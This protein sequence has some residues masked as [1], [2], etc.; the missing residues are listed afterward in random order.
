[1]IYKD[2]SIYLMLS[3][4]VTRENWELNPQMFKQNKKIMF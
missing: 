1:M 4:D 3:L 2:N